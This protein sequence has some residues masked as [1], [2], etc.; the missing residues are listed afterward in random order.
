MR[1]T[2]DTAWYYWEAGILASL[3]AMFNAPVDSAAYAAY[4]TLDIL[5]LYGLSQ[6][7]PLATRRSQ[8]YLPSEVRRQLRNS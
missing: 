5:F 4:G 6:G 8:R 7:A 2:S 1:K 3:F